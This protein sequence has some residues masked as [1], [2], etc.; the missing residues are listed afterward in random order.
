[1]EALT[2]KLSLQRQMLLIAGMS[3]FFGLLPDLVYRGLDE[4]SLQG[5]ALRYALMAAGIAL[6]ILLA[7]L[8]GGH[9]GRRAKHSAEHLLLARL[10]G[11]R[12]CAC[13]ARRPP[14]G[15]SDGR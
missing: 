13:R 9:A 12:L 3:A 6:S 11:P 2:S 1:M 10:L 5:T 8:L 15:R 4:S 7:F 14:G